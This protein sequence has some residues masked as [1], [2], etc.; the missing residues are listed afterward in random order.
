M[1]MDCDNDLELQY[2]MFAENGYGVCGEYIYAGQHPGNLPPAP[3][4]PHSKL[5]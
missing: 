4:P 2:L 5:I 1:D 3:P